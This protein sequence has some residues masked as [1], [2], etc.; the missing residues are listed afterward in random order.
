MEFGLTECLQNY[1]GGLGV[2]SGDHLKSASDLGVPLVGVGLLYQEGYFRQYLNADGYQQESYPI[3]DYSNLPVT[4][5]RDADGEPIMI[6]VPMPGR[7]LYAVIW[8]VQVGR[9]PLYLLDTNIPRKRARRRPQPHRP[10]VRR[11]PP[12]AH[13]A[14]NSGGHRRDSRARQAG[15][16]PE[17]LPHER[18]SR[19]VSRAGTGAPVHERKQRHLLAG[20]RDHG[21]GE[22]LHHPHAGSRRVGALRLRLDRRAFHRL[23]PRTRL[24]P[25]PVHRPRSRAHGRLRVVLDAGAGDQHVGEGER[26][27][28]AARRRLAQ[29]VAVDVSRRAGAGNPDHVD[30]QRHPRRDVDQQRTGRVVRPL[31]ESALAYRRMGRDRLARCR[32]DPRHRTLA[33]PRT[34]PR[35]ADRLHPRAAADAASAPRRAAARDRRTPTRCSTPTR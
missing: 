10:A 27:R 9:V 22:R 5:Q 12:H 13:P 34:P 35:T 31:P 25:Q 33:H 8:K 32:H 23:L 29:A 24:E 21:G 26:R 1:S 2:L 17:S 15:P 6:D 20:K 18:R 28:R 3:N 4:L 19:G 7:K 11:R 14:G 16:A 30:H